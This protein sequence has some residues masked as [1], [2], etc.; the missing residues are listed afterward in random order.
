[1]SLAE[2]AVE[3]PCG[4]AEAQGLPL[5]TFLH[6]TI[7]DAQDRSLYVSCWV[8]QQDTQPSSSSYGKGYYN[9]NRSNLGSKSNSNRRHD[10]YDRSERKNSSGSYSNGYSH[11]KRNHSY[12]HSKYDNHYAQSS[13]VGRS[14]KQRNRKEVEYSCVNQ[15]GNFYTKYSD[16]GYSYKNFNTD[17]RGRTWTSNYYSPN[18]GNSAFYRSSGKKGTS[19]YQNKHKERKYY[20]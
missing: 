12:G 1:M 15:E 7:D 19:F 17:S 5:D 18:G 16:G 11:N 20:K 4:F 3:D 10:S 6:S 9:D 8:S 14:G 13:R 2:W